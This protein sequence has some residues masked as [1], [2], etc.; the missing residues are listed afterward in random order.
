MNFVS[1]GENYLVTHLLQMSI[2]IINCPIV[3]K[4]MSLYLRFWII[5]LLYSYW[6]VLDF[7]LKQNSYFLGQS[8]A[9]EKLSIIPMLQVRTPLKIG[10]TIYVDRLKSSVPLTTVAK[11]FS[12]FGNV[13][14]VFPK[15]GNNP[16][17]NR[18]FC[19][20][21]FEEESNVQAALGTKEHKVWYYTLWWLLHLQVTIRRLQVTLLEGCR[22]HY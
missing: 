1:V 10:F 20:V 13:T 12:Q 22:S 17:K 16:N 4:F 2:F 8:F 7:F 3:W 14:S 11:H 5:V 6:M 21:E 19:F 9:F 15:A 18:G